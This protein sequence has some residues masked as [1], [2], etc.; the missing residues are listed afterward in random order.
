[1]DSYILKKKKR[2]KKFDFSPLNFSWI[3]VFTHNVKLY[4]YK[5]CNE[6]ARNAQM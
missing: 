4:F 2:N 3:E 5:T 6:K 1:M